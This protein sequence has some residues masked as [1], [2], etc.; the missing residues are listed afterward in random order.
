[1]PQTAKKA[2]A[3]QYVLG[4]E[5]GG[6]KTTWALL[7]KEEKIVREGRTTAGNLEHLTEAQLGKMIQSIRLAAGADVS[8]VGGAFAGCHLP[9][10]KRRVEAWVRRYWPAVGPVVIGE[11]TR[12]AFA[13]AHGRGEGIIVIAGTGANVQGHARGRWEKAG[14]W[15]ALFS[16]P[17]SAYDIA[18]RG[19]ETAFVHF[20]QTQEITALGHEYLRRTGQ[21]GMAE[22]V[23]WMLSHSGKTE[24]A[25][26]SEAVFAAAH[27]GDRL[28]RRLLEERSG[29]LAD[30]VADIARRMKLKNPP[31][32]LIGGLF[33]KVPEYVRLFTRQVRKR[34]AVGPIF[35][36]R[37]P[38]AVGAARLVSGLAGPAPVV[39][40]KEAPAESYGGLVTEGR[41]PRSRGLEKKS[42][43]QLVELF[44]SEER[45]VEEALR[46][47]KPQLAA[48]AS[49]VAAA[50]ARKGRCF[51]VGAGT[52]GR[53]GV[54]DASE[55]PPTFN[56]APDLFQ[57]I[58]AG[59]FAALLKAQEGAEDDAGAGASSVQARGVRKGD[60]VVGI[61]ASG[62]APFVRGALEEA[63]RRGAKTVFLTCNPDHKRL[64]GALPLVLETGP[65]L[66]TGSTRLK[67]GTAT[68]A[69]LNILSTVAM[70]RTGR[71]KDNLMVNVQPTNRKLR[72]RARRLVM[73]LAKVDAA[74][75]EK[76]LEKA[77]WDVA[78]A[79]S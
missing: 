30:R 4:I 60:V 66:V 61:T 53:L 34:V 79:V 33:E 22:L 38:G 41:N 57:G 35:V 46:K 58:I 13:G 45:R 70:I 78:R 3:P 65:E 26:L 7:D 50:V 49:A 23:D 17:G 77:G 31:V 6:T 14:G 40:P 19:L 21:N 55:M 69:A 51:Y 11:D 24:V 43:A 8:A 18:R 63:R 68:K 2:S 37:V 67:A 44:V 1:M 28:A 12:S 48:A 73:T 47:A 32:G 72:D 75:A 56:V 27:K 42:V 20:D 59:G 54:L 52:S 76:R 62:T 64:P 15:G 9:K 29:V 5:G 10:E 39:A 74:A 71:V 36:S 16:D 25:A